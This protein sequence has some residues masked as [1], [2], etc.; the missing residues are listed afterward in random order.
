LAGKETAAV[1]WTVSGPWPVFEYANNIG[2]ANAGE[3]TSAQNSTWS[4]DHA[5]FVIP[6]QR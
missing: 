1:A 3:C 2:T 4:C 5:D 6:D